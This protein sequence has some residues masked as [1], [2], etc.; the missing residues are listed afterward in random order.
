MQILIKK[1]KHL[2]FCDER[3]IRPDGE[4]RGFLSIRSPCPKGTRY[5]H[6]E[7]NGDCPF[8]SLFY[9]REGLSPFEK[10]EYSVGIFYE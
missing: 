10:R 3:N 5:R 7:K 8:K 6:I 4:E 1:G 2:Y 9:R